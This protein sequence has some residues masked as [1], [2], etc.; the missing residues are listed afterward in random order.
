M[1]ALSRKLITLGV[2]AGMSLPAAA[3]INNTIYFMHGV[4]Q[5]N[6]IN[7]AFQ[8]KCRFYFGMTPWRVELS[9]SSLAYGD[10]IY[11]HPTQ[12]DSLITFLHPEGD[13]DAFLELLKPVN[14]VASDFGT[15]L[16]YVGFRTGV[17]FFT[18][19]LSTRWDGNIY[20]PGDLARLMIN[21]AVD[22][23]NYQL[24]GIGADL[25]LMD[26]VSIGWSRAIMDNLNIGVRAKVL[27]GVANLSTL[28][29]DL[30]VYT[31]KEVWTIQSDMKFN[32]SIPFAEVTYDEDGMM[33]DIMIKEDL[34]NPSVSTIS[35]YMF[36]GKNLGLGLDLGVDYRPMD[37]LQI[38]ASVMDLGYIRWKDEVHQV[39]YAMEYDYKG[40]EVNPFDFS[41]DYT[42]GDHLDSTLSEMTD[43]L[44]GFLEFSPGG[45]YSKM[46]NTKLYVGA[47]YDITPNINLGLLSRTDFLNGRVAEQ[48]T[49]SANFTTGRV[50][51]LTLSYSYMNAYYKNIGVGISFNFGFYNLY[52]V[53]DNA[54][55]SLFWPEETRSIN[56]WY[57]A[58]LLF[59]YKEF[60]KGGDWDRPLIY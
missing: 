42:F 55:N 52:L 18:L 33:E 46:L 2:I 30:S 57:G 17:G 41:E 15:S 22:N 14:F 12:P 11:Q 31:S 44:S 47:S 38:S 35:R 59:G 40:I 58:N 5:S 6:R 4:P 60:K 34:E 56:L 37:Q 28:S 49:A 51:N 29:S 53:S 25:T 16:G 45:V 24:D 26:E 43:S 27:F 19:D 36:N 21:G 54:L 8:P 23:T 3:Q 48:V 9:S 7:P 39:N 50:V 13:K 10:V 32:A 20:Y 1:K